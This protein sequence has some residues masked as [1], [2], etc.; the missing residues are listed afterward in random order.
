M[1]TN[2]TICRIFGTTPINA[3]RKFERSLMSAWDRSTRLIFRAPGDRV[4][5]RVSEYT[6]LRVAYTLILE[7][8]AHESLAPPFLFRQPCAARPGSEKA[9]RGNAEHPFGGGG[10]HSRLGPG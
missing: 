2:K 1:D 4:I 6:P 7:F 5:A 8:H 10:E 9:G 3:D